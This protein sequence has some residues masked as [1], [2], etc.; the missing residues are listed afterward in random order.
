M[1]WLFNIEYLKY[2]E[3]LCE[4]IN[5]LT[6]LI[7]SIVGALFGFVA[8]IIL[9]VCLRKKVMVQRKYLILKILSYS[10]W[11]L[12]P[13]FLSFCAMQ[14]SA[15][16]NVERQVVKNIPKYLGETNE[17]FNLY[18][19]AEFEKIISEEIRQS[20]SNKLLGKAVTGVQGVAG[21]YLKSLAKE[22]AEAEADSQLKKGMNMAS[23]YLAGVVMESSFVKEKVL[24]EIR[25]KV[26]ST[27]LMNEEL[28]N[29]LFEVEFQR[30]LD[31]GVINTVLEKQ[32]RNIVGGFKL[33][34]WIM[35]LL[36]M[37]FP[38]SEIVIANWMHSKKKKESVPDIVEETLS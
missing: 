34:V 31:N 10:Y 6:V 19:R 22:T 20:N 29:E 21:S 32:V 7:W 8:G 5:P 28:T 33:N 14:W 16:H 37:L 13:L 25:K 12:V 26:G 11:V 38:V 15:L 23:S 24:S 9:L 35:L 18:L 30:F 2:W 1:D 3:L 36:G 27:L 17:L 4:Y